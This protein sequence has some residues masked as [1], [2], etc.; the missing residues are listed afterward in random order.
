MSE[1]FALKPLNRESF[2]SFYLPANSL[3]SYAALSINIMNP[4]LRTR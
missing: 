3:V 2:V 4:A 1:K